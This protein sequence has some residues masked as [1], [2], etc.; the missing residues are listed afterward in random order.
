M[1][2]LNEVFPGCSSFS[3]SAQNRNHTYDVF[4]SFRGTDTRNRF[5]DHLYNALLDADINTFLDDED[6]ETGD[7]LKPELESAIQSSR[8]S[9]IVLSENYASSTWCLDELVLILEQKRAFNQIVIPIFYHVEPTDVGKQQSSFGE[10]MEKHKRR[11]ETEKRS[12]FAQKMESWKRA[13]TEVADL[14]GKDVKGRKETEFIEEVVTDI[15]RR[16]GVLLSDTLP[17]LIGMDGYIKSITSWLTDMSWH[18]VNILTVVGMGGIGKTSLAKYVFLLHSSKFYG[19][20]FVEGIG[21]RCNEQFNGLL[22]LQKQLHRDISGKDLLQVND[23]SMYTAKIEKVLARKMVFIVLDDIGSLDQLDALLG[24]KGL[25]PGSKVII[26]TKDASL[27]KMCAL[28]NPQLQPK[29][30]M[31]MLNGLN[32]SE[33]LELLCIHAFQSQKPREGYK[34]VSKKLVMYCDGHPLALEV[35]GKSLH[36]QDVAYW[37]DCIQGLQKEPQ[38]A[39]KYSLQT[40]ID[41]LPSKND[42]ELFMHIACFFVGEDKD[43]TETILDACEINTR[44][45]ITVLIDRCLLSIEQNNKLAMHSLIQEMGRYLVRQESR[46]KPSM[47]RRLWCHNDSFDVLKKEKGTGSLLGLALDMRMLDKK[48]S[49]GSLELKTGSLSKMHNLMLLQLNF[50]QLS[51]SFKN[52]PRQL[53]WLCMHGFPLKSITID[54][55][56][57][58]LVALDISYSNIESFDVLDIKSQPP[59]KRQKLVG[60]WSKDKQLLGSLKILDLSFCEQLHSL[61]GFP[62][63]PALERLTVRNC[64]SLIEVSESVEQCVD[65]VHFDLRYCYKL[66]RLPTSVGKLNKLRTL[67]LD[68]CDLG[69]SAIMSS[70]DIGINSQISSVAIVEAIP[71]DWKFFSTSL[72][73][74]LVTLSLANNKLCSESFPLDFSCLPVLQELCLDNNPIVSMPSCVRSLRRLEK[75]SMNHCHEDCNTWLRKITFDP[76]MSPRTLCGAS[77]IL[78]PWSFEI[79]GMVKIQP[80]AG[81]DGK[82]LQSLGWS[83]LEFIRERR[84]RTYAFSGSQES[85]TQ[86]YYEF[87]IF[88]TFYEGKGMP[89]WISHTSKG[90][91]ISFT[92]PSSP[93]KLQGLNFCYLETHPDPFFEVPVIKISNI[94][95]NQTWIYHH[96]IEGVK[97]GGKCLSWLSHWMFG[98]NEMR[99][100]DHITII[101]APRTDGMI[102]EE[103]DALAYCGSWDESGDQIIAGFCQLTMEC[104]ISL[105][106]DEDGKIEEDEEDVLGYYKLWNHIIGGDLSAFQ[107]TTGEYILDNRTFMQNI[108]KTYSRSHSFT[109]GCP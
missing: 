17:R 94:T 42:K 98:P 107:S 61:G 33:S 72:S 34:E 66:K 78:S 6:I 36:K 35:L 86:M 39:V 26:T 16:F 70:P 85:Q 23:V 73:R 108:S 92:I 101:V 31:V 25:H 64:I 81:V 106:Y 14:K 84:L 75:L 93:E 40:G 20:S 22:D 10:A 41:S 71:S 45:G 3:P 47:R 80:I 69:Q 5:T 4:L 76:E 109:A 88:S 27:T 15:H 96:R 63:L 21:T 2:V 8:A 54:V 58:Y 104:G 56:M 28:F 100:G 87:G 89:D 44:S 48:E 9:I 105:V 52:F 50:V 77:K 46:N 74:S 55:P 24:S 18:T 1:A 49:H 65:L 37:E 62:E 60:S 43:L 19:S 7:S 83:N 38:P 59:T 99:G 30:K 102:E 90:P 97:L 13:L 103:E 51:G 12:G 11:M 32:G 29:H 57:E 82:V 95:K 67:F 68:G 79:D 91:S 53:R